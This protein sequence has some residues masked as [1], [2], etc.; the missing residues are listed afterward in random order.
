MVLLSDFDRQIPSFLSASL[1]TIRVH[2]SSFE[3]HEKMP[4]SST[5]LPHF[6]PFDGVQWY[7]HWGKKKEK[8]SRI[9]THFWFSRP[10]AVSPWQWFDGRQESEKKEAPQGPM[11]RRNA[12]STRFSNK[13]RARRLMS[14][15]PSTNDEEMDFDG[16]PPN[17]PWLLPIRFVQGRGK[18]QGRKR[19]ASEPTS[20]HA[21]DNCLSHV[22]SGSSSRT[23]L[24][25]L[26]LFAALAA[27]TA[28]ASRAS[29]TSSSRT[30]RWS[31]WQKTLN[32]K[33]F[34]WINEKLLFLFKK[35]RP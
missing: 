8:R 19:I 21:I 22:A 17:R 2:F 10:S 4:S 18:A 5:R 27:T 9:F 35:Q 15:R 24:G 6:A 16:S 33:Q 13:Q 3:C 28:T 32:W 7:M 30:R 23:P 34:S 11:T 12:E 20:K 25:L 1:R 31:S 29:A 14:S 26:A